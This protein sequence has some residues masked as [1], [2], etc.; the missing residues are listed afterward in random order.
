MS[1]AFGAARHLPGSVAVSA[2]QCWTLEL[3]QARAHTPH[4]RLSHRAL[5]LTLLTL[6]SCSTQAI[7]SS[8]PKPPVLN[9]EAPRRDDA[10]TFLC[11]IGD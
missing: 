2:L 8:S 10:A 1:T 5:G 4:G 3:T 6:C 11:I 9:I 7:H